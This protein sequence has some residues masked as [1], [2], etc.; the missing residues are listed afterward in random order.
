MG[1]ALAPPE[2][3]QNLEKHRMTLL[4]FAGVAAATASYQ[5]LEF[6]KFSRPAS[7]TAWR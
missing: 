5:D 6:Q 7:R 3:I 4:G 2:L 1:Y